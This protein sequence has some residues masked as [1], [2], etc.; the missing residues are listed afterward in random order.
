MRS[1]KCGAG[2]GKP[3]D[4]DEEVLID[5]GYGDDANDDYEDG[6]DDYDEVMKMMMM[7]IVIVVVVDDD[8]DGTWKAPLSKLR[9]ARQSPN[10]ALTSS[11]VNLM[12]IVIVIQVMISII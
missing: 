7:I 4:E 2:Q 10:T 12:I 1:T 6:Y 8:D 11:F 9:E 3:G 5:D